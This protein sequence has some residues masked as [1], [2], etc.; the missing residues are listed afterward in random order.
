MCGIVGIVD[1]ATLPRLGDVRHAL[2]LMRHRGPDGEGTWSRDDGGPPFVVLGHKRLAIID[3]TDAGA[4]PMGT[5]DRSLWIT[6]NGELYNYL[7]LRARL[8]GL[9]RVFRSDSD[10]EVILQAYEE[11]GRRS[12]DSFNGMFAFAI[13]DERRR[14]LFAA[15]DRF[16]EKPFHYSWDAASGRFAFASEI[17]AL[18]SLPTV[19]KGLDDRALYRFIRF[20]ELAASDQT[21][22]A[23]VRRLRHAHWLELS[24]VGDRFTLSTAPYWDV[25]LDHREELSREEAASR[26]RELFADS[27]RLRLRSDVAVGTSLS[28]GLDSSSVICQIQR[29]GAAE[30]QKAFSARMED[31]ELDEGRHIRRVLQATGIPGYEVWPSAE[32]LERLFSRLCY[33]LEEPFPTTSQFAQHLVMRLA[34]EHGVTVLLDGQ[35]ADELLAGYR[36]YFFTRYLDLASGWRLAALGREL[37]AFRRRHGQALPLS[38]KAVAARL[39]PSL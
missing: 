28:G 2:D 30:G 13:W 1:A 29:L 11:W 26:F 39:A 21:L 24:W 4:Q 23:D 12:L 8:E 3:L 34:S 19:S 10:T 32:E 5:V 14:T 38:A 7:E 16:G 18:L 27:V 17:K 25:D 15:R 35:G 31:P 33:A 9:G 37:L 20:R 36:P 22:W 6:Y